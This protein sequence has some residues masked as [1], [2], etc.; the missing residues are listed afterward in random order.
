MKTVISNA[1]KH[2]KKIFVVGRSIKRAI[3]TAIEEKL[4]DNF[5]ILNEKLFADYNRDNV[6]LICTGSQG[7][8]N[9]ALSKIANNTHNHIK[10]SP[11]IILFSHQR[12]SGNEKAISYLKN[13]FP[14]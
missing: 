7:E 12:N 8:K 2:K 1:I 13:S 3:T 11:K 10:L 9:S 6:V 5:E 4:I 14:I